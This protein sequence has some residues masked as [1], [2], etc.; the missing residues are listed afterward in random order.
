MGQFPF[1]LP[2]SDV[3]SL[4]GTQHF[5][6][7]FRVYHADSPPGCQMMLVHTS[8]PWHDN[9][10]G[11]VSP[12]S[13]VMAEHL[14][15]TTKAA[16]HARGTSECSRGPLP[17]LTEEAGIQGGL[18]GPALLQQGHCPSARQLGTA[19]TQS[20]LGVLRPGSCPKC[21]PA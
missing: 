6:E 20:L 3:F 7:F 8:S 9:T 11:S 10:R 18:P 2:F 19:G 15:P 14:V 17:T 1:M 5:N 4:A 16:R 13:P 21:I 12:G